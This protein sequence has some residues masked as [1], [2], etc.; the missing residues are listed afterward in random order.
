MDKDQTL[1]VKLGFTLTTPPV[2]IARVTPNGDLPGLSVVFTRAD[3][4]QIN[5]FNVP[6]EVAHE[7][8]VGKKVTHIVAVIDE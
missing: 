8:P 7:F 2:T 3:D 6:S 4:G 5:S 1:D